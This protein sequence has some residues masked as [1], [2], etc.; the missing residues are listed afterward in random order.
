VKISL[1]KSKDDKCASLLITSL[2]DQNISVQIQS[3]KF[4]YN[5]QKLNLEKIELAESLKEMNYASKIMRHQKNMSQEINGAIAFEKDMG[6]VVANV[7]PTD[8]DSHYLS[9]S[10]LDQVEIGQL[11]FN[12]NLDLEDIVI[13]DP[14]VT[15]KYGKLFSSIFYEIV[16]SPEK[17]NQIL[18]TS[19]LDNH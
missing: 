13:S 10:L 9:M 14:I 11:C 19:T 5:T 6:F 4:Y 18:L 3:Y 1:Q 15:G 7:I 12:E 2:E 17:E 16:P 8:S